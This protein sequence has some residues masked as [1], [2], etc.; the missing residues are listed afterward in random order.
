MK[1]KKPNFCIQQDDKNIKFSKQ[2]EMVPANEKIGI[3]YSNTV[4]SEVLY[5][6]KD[7]CCSASSINQDIETIHLTKPLTPMEDNPLRRESKKVPLE[8]SPL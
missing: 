2:F 3:K 6:K 8:D 7:N 5:S 4:R 1:I